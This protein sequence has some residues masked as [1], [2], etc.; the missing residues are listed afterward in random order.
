[1]ASLSGKFI[2]RRPWRRLARRLFKT[3][4]IVPTVKYKVGDGEAFMGPAVNALAFAGPAA[5]A[6]AA[7]RSAVGAVA[8]AGPASDAKS[9]IGKAVDGTASIG[10]D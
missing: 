6:S 7:C 1:M 9:H 2:Y 8:F 4:F 10:V 5:D 3:R